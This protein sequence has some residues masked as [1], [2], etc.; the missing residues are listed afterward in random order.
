MRQGCLQ[1]VE[2]IELIAQK[3]QDQRQFKS[4]CSYPS[5]KDFTLTE[6]I[7][8]KDDIDSEH[9][10]VSINSTFFQFE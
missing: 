2:L 3:S 8:L 10:F 4:P 1:G 5:Y 7:E 9:G 6:N